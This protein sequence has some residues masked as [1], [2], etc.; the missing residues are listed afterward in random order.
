VVPSGTMAIHSV[1]MLDYLV[2]GIGTEII[3]LVE[4]QTT[5]SCL[6]RH[7]FDICHVYSFFGVH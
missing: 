7:H 3:V 2:L 1:E 4:H 5:T 6:D